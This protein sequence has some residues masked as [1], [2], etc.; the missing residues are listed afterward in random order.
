MVRISSISE[1]WV[2]KGC[3]I[4]VDSIELS[5]LPDHRG[6]IVFK[7]VF[8]STSDMDC[9]V[10][11]RIATQILQDANWRRKLRGTLARAMEYLLGVRGQ[12]MSKAR[13]KLLELKFL[14]VA[15]DRLGGM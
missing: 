12:K 15:L 10:A 5:V 11:I 2:G 13:G 8:S 3:H 9:D 1:D 14:I 4:H 6:G 7:K